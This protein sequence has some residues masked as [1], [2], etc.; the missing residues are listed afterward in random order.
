MR[1]TNIDQYEV[2][3]I[4]KPR[5]ERVDAANLAAEEVSCVAPEYEN[6]RLLPPVL[7]EFERLI[8]VAANNVEL[9]I[10]RFFSFGRCF[11]NRRW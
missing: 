9:E 7:R 5:V 10:W 2:R 11:G 6:N 8:L 3:Y 1:F 4:T